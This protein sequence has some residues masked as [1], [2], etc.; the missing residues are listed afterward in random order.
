M[1]RKTEDL[2]RSLLSLGFDV[3]RFARVRSP[4]PSSAAF[5]D[6]LAKGYQGDM[7]W[8]ERSILKRSN[9][10][11]V[12]SGA[13]SIILLGVNYL[14]KTQPE[15]DTHWARY[16]QYLDYHD[17]LKPALQEA[18]RVLESWGGLTRSD[19]RY[20]TDTGPVLERA[21]AAE[22][23]VGFV[24]K[25]AMLISREFGNWLFLSAIISIADLSADPPVS[26]NYAKKP[27]GTLCGS[28]TKCMTACPT[29]ALRAPG[30]LD[31]KRCI[32]YL[33]IELKGMVPVEWRSAIGNH[34]YGCDICAEVCPW[35]R[36]A[37]TSRSVLLT[38]RPGLA[39]LKLREIL[40]LT[41]EQFAEVFRGTAIKRL[42]LRGLLRNACIVAANTSARD[43]LPLIERLAVSHPEEIV[44]AH[45]VWALR[46]LVPARSLRDMR[47][48]ESSAVVLGEYD[49]K[50]LR[51]ETPP[52]RVE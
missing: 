38:P 31:A 12:V 2:R 3:V 21:W 22:S 4:S 25:N 6:W 28:C 39:A 10:G 20:Y 48:R 46:V 7:S 19:Y 8:L 41:P 23:G 44:R 49:R 35:N 40:S 24:G 27:I 17:T 9:A 1:P 15:N 36:F 51:P 13:R 50:E 11:E 29:E 47:E 37:Q 52:A 42:K 16:A 33:T 34:L 45:A 18:G 5:K 14:P 26:R 30:V 43:C 32:S